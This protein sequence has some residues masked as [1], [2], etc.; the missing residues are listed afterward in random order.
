[1]VVA[2]ADAGLMAH[3]EWLFLTGTLGGRQNF[4][5]GENAYRAP[6][7]AANAM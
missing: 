4:A 7:L 3:Y 5:V 2:G 6:S 1:L